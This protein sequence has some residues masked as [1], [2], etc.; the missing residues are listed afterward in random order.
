MH[1]QNVRKQIN[2]GL[3]AGV[4]YTVIH[5]CKLQTEQRHCIRQVLFLIVRNFAFFS[6]HHLALIFT[7][8]FGVKLPQESDI[9]SASITAFVSDEENCTDHCEPQSKVFGLLNLVATC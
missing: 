4:G 9:A 2:S 7:T 6:N 3:S 5:I 1:M 8:L